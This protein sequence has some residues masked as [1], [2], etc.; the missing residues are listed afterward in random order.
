VSEWVSLPPLLVA[1]EPRYSQLMTTPTGA[2]FPQRQIDVLFVW[3]FGWFFV[4]FWFD[5]CFCFCETG[6]L[7]I[8]LAIL[9]LTL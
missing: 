1:V 3:L 6:F 9:E 2:R 4:L 7:R 5:F 8:A